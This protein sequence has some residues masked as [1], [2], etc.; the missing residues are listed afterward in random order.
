MKRDHDLKTFTRAY[1]VG[2]AVYV[3]DT[4]AVK[5]KCRKLCPTWK[6]PGVVTRKLSD[7]V[8][9][10]RLRQKLVTI[11]NH[12]LKLC[13]DRKLPVLVTNYRE[14]FGTKGD[15]SGS[16]ACTNQYCICRGP[17]DGTFMIQCDE[18][19]EWFHGKCVDITPE[20]AKVIDIY[21]CANCC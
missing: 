10:I 16:L 1:K 7:Y 20:K 6:G 4:A 17:D 18:C 11:N 21:L 3:L 8:Y 15:Q 19:R 14:R 12:R 13:N 2:D 5:G 9:E